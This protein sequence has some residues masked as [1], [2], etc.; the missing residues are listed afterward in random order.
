MQGAGAKLHARTV[1]LSHSASTVKMRRGCQFSGRSRSSGSISEPSDSAAC[2]THCAFSQRRKSREDLVILFM[3]SLTS[4]SA[5]S[6]VRP[7]GRTVRGT[8][9]GACP[10]NHLS[11]QQYSEYPFHVITVFGHY[12]AILLLPLWAFTVLYSE[13]YIIS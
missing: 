3:R 6:P 13:L 11:G 5:S 2:F 7:V 4:Q 12:R 9:L 8:A 1:T 10:S